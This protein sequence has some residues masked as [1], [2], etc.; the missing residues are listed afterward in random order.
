MWGLCL[1][2][3]SQDVL[4]PSSLALLHYIEKDDVRHELI[5]HPRIF[6]HRLPLANA[7]DS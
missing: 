5:Q 6:L 2:R 1:A 7:A 3:T 4:N